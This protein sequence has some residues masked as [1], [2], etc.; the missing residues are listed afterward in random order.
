MISEGV[1]TRTHT[2]F[3]KVLEGW[4]PFVPHKIL[5]TIGLTLLGVED[6]IGGALPSEIPSEIL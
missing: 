3:G 1:D 5:I 6:E 2:L 4:G